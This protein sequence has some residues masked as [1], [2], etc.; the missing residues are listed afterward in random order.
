MT[1]CKS[2]NCV[3][4]TI[5]EKPMPANL[6]IITGPREAGKTVFCRHLI[7]AARTAGWRVGGMLC[8]A[9]FENDRKTGIEAEAL[10]TGLRL[11]L[12]SL[13]RA[14]QP[15]SGLVTRRWQFDAE[16]LTWGNR[17][18]GSATPCDLLV[19]DELGP[20]EFERDEGWTAGLAALDGG[21]YRSGV[22][23][24]RPELL[25]AARHRW[26]A[27]E[28]IIIEQATSSRPAAEQLAARL[29]GA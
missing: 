9:M 22:V 29:F 17:M 15:Q 6:F 21:N 24:I 1:N 20:L 19:V 28:V 7:E 25:D 2:L 26:P 10:H 11:Q 27:A 3:D 8:P 16:V 12:A 14:D 5:V 18:L 13:R 23:V 4:E